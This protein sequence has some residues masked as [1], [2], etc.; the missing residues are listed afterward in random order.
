ML[1]YDSIEKP[2]IKTK[3]TPRDFSDLQLSGE[4]IEK[5]KNDM[6]KKI[7]PDVDDFGKK[8]GRDLLHAQASFFRFWSRSFSSVRKPIL[9]FFYSLESWES[10]LFVSVHHFWFLL[11]DIG[12]N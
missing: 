4:S 8:S 12:V 10:E 7:W 5:Q 9:M 2:K 1:P 11:Y 6:R 3:R